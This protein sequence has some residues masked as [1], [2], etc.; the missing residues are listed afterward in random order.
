MANEKVFV[1]INLMTKEKMTLDKLAQIIAL[2][3]SDLR[4]ELKGDINGLEGKMIGLK[5]DIEYLTHETGNIERILRAEI[6]RDDRQDEKIDY[7]ERKVGLV[8]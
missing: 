5:G 2:G 3:F 6:G 1:K 8:K 4:T 7:L